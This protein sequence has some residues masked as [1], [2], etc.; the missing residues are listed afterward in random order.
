MKIKKDKDRK[1]MKTNVSNHQAGKGKS[2]GKRL[3]DARSGRAYKVC[4]RCGEKLPLEDFYWNGARRRSDHYCKCCRR[5]SSMRY[6][7][8]RCLVRLNTCLRPA[9][10][11]IFDEPDSDRRMELILQARSVVRASILR[12]RGR[13]SAGEDMRIDRDLDREEP[14]FPENPSGDGSDS[15]DLNPQNSTSHG[16]DK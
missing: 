3:P 2:S 12:K 15:P 6:R 1:K 5:S 4:A 8:D 9:H 16:T 11:T 7:D 13:E 10:V 14:S